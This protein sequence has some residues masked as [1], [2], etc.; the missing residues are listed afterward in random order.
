MAK[1]AI[2]NNNLHIANKYLDVAKYI[3]ENDFRYYYYQG[4]VFKAKG[5]TQDAIFYFKKS[6]AINPDNISAKKE[7]GI[8]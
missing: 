3:D 1:V 8:L 6:L 2:E 4:L 7:L 5:M